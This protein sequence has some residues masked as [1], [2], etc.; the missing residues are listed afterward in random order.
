M[1][2]FR[3]AKIPMRA[4]DPTRRY[5]IVRGEEDV[6]VGRLEIGG[7]VP[8][9][10]SVVL[11]VDCRAVLAETERESVL[12]TARRFLDELVAGWGHQVAEVPG[13]REWAPQPDGVHRMRI[14]YQV[15][16]ANL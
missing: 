15:V 5:R 8:D 2:V 9:G 6:T 4:N 1:D 16:C 3:F 14:E 10:D 11:T 12:S 13:A 7:D